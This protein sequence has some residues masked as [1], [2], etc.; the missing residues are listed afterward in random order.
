M[1]QNSAHTG[2]LYVVGT[3]IGNLGDLSPR[4]GE[5]FAA[6]ECVA[7]HIGQFHKFCQ[8]IINFLRHR[9]TGE[10]PDIHIIFPDGHLFCVAFSF[11]RSRHNGISGFRDHTDRPFKNRP[12][13]RYI[14]QIF[15]AVFI[16]VDQ[17]RIKVPGC[18]F[19]LETHDS[20][21][22]FT[23]W[24]HDTHFFD[25]FFCYSVKIFLHFSGRH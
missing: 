15:F 8:R 6:A 2:K 19:R 16:A 22:K 9:H 5:A 1:T 18:H 13:V 4:V 25:P 14:P 10:F 12:E 21:L 24:N 3:P 23:L 11:R 7:D 17:N 20:F